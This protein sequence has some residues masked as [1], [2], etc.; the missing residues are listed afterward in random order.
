MLEAILLFREIPTARRAIAVGADWATRPAKIERRRRARGDRS[1][2]LRRD[3]FQEA[4]L[5]ELYSK[6]IDARPY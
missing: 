1:S 5:V 3:R 6:E 2:A 4:A